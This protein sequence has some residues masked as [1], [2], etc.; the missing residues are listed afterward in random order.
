MLAHRLGALCGRAVVLF[1]HACLG[2]ITCTTST[3]RSV[4][5][6]QSTSVLSRVRGFPTVA[7]YGVCVD[8]SVGG[9]LWA[10]KWNL[11]A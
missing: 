6:W 2:F 3:I 4:G 1:A 10:S 5:W 7:T 9:A 11:D 8:A